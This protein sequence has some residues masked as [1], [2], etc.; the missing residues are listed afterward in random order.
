[1]N[2]SNARA[3]KAI[4]L[5][6]GAPLALYLLIFHHWRC[7]TGTEQVTAVVLTLAG[8]IAAMNWA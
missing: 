3:W 7:E 8:F 2:E 6:V 4:G 5:T 1:M